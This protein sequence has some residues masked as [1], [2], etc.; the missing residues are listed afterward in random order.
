MPT[1]DTELEQTLAAARWEAYL[2]G[3]P[4]V[5]SAHLL[6]GLLHWPQSRAVRMLRV[7]GVEPRWDRLR[8][9]VADAATWPPAPDAVAP[10]VPLSDEAHRVLNLADAEAKERG[11][12]TLCPED[13]VVGLLQV[14]RGLGGMLLRAHGLTVN[15]WRRALASHPS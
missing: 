1:P 5:D 14:P 13:L 9:P 15:K 10:P 2:S 11:S 6:L 12:E 3:R 7:L 4:Q 8:G